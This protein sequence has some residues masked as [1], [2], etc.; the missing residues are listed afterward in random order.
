MSAANFRTLLVRAGP[1]SRL[2]L[3]RLIEAS[4]IVIDDVVEPDDV[5]ANITPAN[6]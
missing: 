6:S 1:A 3:S 2:L 4:D 5:L